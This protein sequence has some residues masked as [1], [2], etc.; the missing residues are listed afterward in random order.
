MSASDL[1]VAVAH[2][3][4]HR[5]V[6]PEVAGSRPVSHPIS[7]FCVLAGEAAAFE[8][9]C[10]RAEFKKAGPRPRGFIGSLLAIPSTSHVQTGFFIHT[11][12]SCIRMIDP[13][14]TI[15]MGFIDGTLL[16]CSMNA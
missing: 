14:N 5:I 6:A 9:R 2:Q 8:L 12:S 10:L 3:V 15:C 1:M 4:E 16:A 11:C 7:L 13:T